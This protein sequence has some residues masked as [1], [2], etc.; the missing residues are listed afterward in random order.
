M[1]NV[2]KVVTKEINI[3]G[4][5]KQKNEKVQIKVKIRLDIHYNVTSIG[6]NGPLNN[7]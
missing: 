3:L 6:G 2:V 4:V 1:L 5:L 7:K